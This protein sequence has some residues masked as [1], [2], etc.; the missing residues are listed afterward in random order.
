MRCL[1][2]DLSTFV[3]WAYFARPTGKPKLGTFRLPITSWHDNYGP[4]FHALDQWLDGMVTTM[5]PALLAFEAPLTPV[6]GKSWAINTDA[7]TVRLLTGLATIA[8]LVAT[9]HRLRCIEVAVTTAKAR[10]AG[11]RF[12][13]KQQMVAACVRRDWR[14]ADDHQADACGVAL[15]AYDHVGQLP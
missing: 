13:T 3:G 1:A 6:D 8:E 10:L 4:R 2:L 11:T 5:R 9:R 12:A 14:V 7:D 15:A